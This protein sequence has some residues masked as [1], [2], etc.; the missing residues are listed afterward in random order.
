[1]QC[2]RLVDDKISEELGWG[3]YA[4]NK[5]AKQLND[6]PFSF[7]RA[8]HNNF[9]V[10][11]KELLN[12]Y[13]YGAGAKYIIGELHVTHPEIEPSTSKRWLYWRSRK[14]KIGDGSSQIFKGSI[15]TI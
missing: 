11:S 8:R 9:Q 5:S 2:F 12:G 15:Y 10:G 6:L 13:H 4:L 1:M 14:K 3:W 7:L